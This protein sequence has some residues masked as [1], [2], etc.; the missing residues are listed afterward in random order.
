[1]IGRLSAGMAVAL[2][3][4]GVALGAERPETPGR[5]SPAPHAAT[6]PRAPDPSDLEAADLG[7]WVIAAEGA[8]EEEIPAVAPGTAPDAT[9]AR[10]A[11][12][13]DHAMAQV[14][15]D[16]EPFFD[17]VLYVSKAREGGFAQRMYVYKRGVDGVLLPYAQWLVSTGRERQEEKGFTTTPIGLFKVDPD[18]MFRMWRSRKWDGAPMP[19]AMFYDAEFNGRLT[20]LAMHSATGSGLERLGRRASGGCIRLHPEH[21]EHL[22]HIIKDK[23]AGQVPVF[24][25][26]SDTVRTTARD[27]RV[28]RDEGGAIVTTLGLRVVLVID[29]FTGDAPPAAPSTTPVALAHAR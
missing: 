13:F 18:R 9:P 20:G 15:D 1:M 22:F 28:V 23:M 4:G 14:P 27:G 2:V 6:T 21:A 17:L 5:P 12:G 25:Y 29:D 3:F 11:F 19:W 8:A 26:I 7:G 10:I 16:I 24:P